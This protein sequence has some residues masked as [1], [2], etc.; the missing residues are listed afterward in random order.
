MY[1][2]KRGMHCLHAC[3]RAGLAYFLLQPDGRQERV[4]FDK[5]TSRV[6]KLAYGLDA[7]HVDPVC[8]AC[9]F[10]AALCS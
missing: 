1:V 9:V 3:M 2:I 4:M 5:I 7:S 10:I 6:A 8:C